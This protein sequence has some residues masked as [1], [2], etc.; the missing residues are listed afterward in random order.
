MKREPLAIV[1]MACRFPGNADSADALWD[2][3]CKGTDAIRE[4][5]VDRWDVRKFFDPDPD[6]LGKGYTR[7]G[8][9]LNES[10]WEFDPAFFGISPR[11][12]AVMDPQQRL[13]LEVTWE[14]FEDAGMVLSDE[15][16]KRVGVFVGAFCFD[17][18]VQQ[19]SQPSRT[20]ISSHTATSAS[21][22]MLSNRISYVFDLQ[23][24]SLTVDT[25]CSS[26]LVTTHLGCQA[27]WDGDCDV[28]VVGGVNVML[29]PESTILECKGG[30]LSK[31]ARCRTFDA[32][33]NGYVRAEGAGVV[34]I[35]PLSAALAAKDRIVAVIRGTGVNQDGRTSSI[36][37]PNGQAQEALIRQVCAATGIDPV[38]IGYVEAHGTGTPV[39]DPIE[40]N[41]LGNAIGQGREQACAPWVG[42]IKT[43][44]GHLEAAAGVA[45]L[46]KA[47]L[48]LQHQQVPPHLHLTRLNPKIDLHT[49]GLRVPQRM[50]VLEPTL[51]R[52]AAINSFGYGGTNAHALIERAP[53]PA[54]VEP[55]VEDRGPWLVPLSARTAGALA[56]YAQAVAQQLRAQPSLSLAAFGHALA[57]KRAHHDHRA[58]IVAHDRAGLL[59]SLAR[60][61]GGET[62]PALRI[63]R[64]SEGRRLVW[65]YTGMGAQ[66]W[67]MGRS[68]FQSNEVFRAAIAACDDAWRHVGGESLSSVFDPAAALAAP[69]G[70]P[71]CEPRDAQPANLA[72]QVGVTQV[73]R[74][75]GLEADAIVGHSVGE[76]GAAWA[77]GAL[78]LQEAFR[79]TYHRSQ[80]QQELLG[81][82]TMLALPMPAAA[83]REQI[84]AL[85]PDVE[86]AAFNDA[87]SVTLSGREEDLLR[88]ADWARTQG[89][90]AQLLRV[91]VAY[92]TRQVDPIRE[93]FHAALAGL[94][95]QP[96]PITLYS[97]VTGAKVAPGEQDV[98]YWWRNAREPVLLSDAMQQLHSDGFDA[99]IEVG[100]HAVLGASILRSVPNAASWPSQRR[101]ASDEQATLLAAA[102][103]AYCAGASIDWRRLYPR[104]D[105][106]LR[107]PRYPFQRETLWR[108]TAASRADRLV[109]EL[110]PLLH[111]RLAQPMPAWR[112]TL[113]E[114]FLPWL[115]DHRI[116]GALVFPG[117]GYAVAAL[118]AAD[119]T[120]RGNAVENLEFSRP[121][122]PSSQTTLQID[123]DPRDGHVSLSSQPPGEDPAWHRH[124][125]ARLPEGRTAAPA[126]CDI[127]QLRARCFTAVDVEQFYRQLNEQGLQ[128][129]P[130]FRCIRALAVGVD[131]AIVTLRSEDVE[132]SRYLVHPALLDAAFQSMLGLPGEGQA[133]G[134]YVPVLV[135]ALRL[136]GPVGQNVIAHVKVSRRTP[137]SIQG[138]IRLLDDT[139]R[140]L[141]AVEGVRCQ[142][143]GAPGTGDDAAK[144]LYAWQWETSPPAEVTEAKGA[145][146]LVLSDH[147]GV[148]R[149][150][151]DAA[152]GLTGLELVCLP[153]DFASSSA[154]SL[155]AYS[156]VI[157]LRAVDLDL[158]GD[159]PSGEAACARL[160]SLVQKLAH[161]G[162]TPPK[163]VVVTHRALPVGRVEVIP[164]SGAVCGLARVAMS[165]LP[166]LA[167]R[168][169]DIDTRGAAEAHYLLAE[170][171]S[172]GDENEV[173]LRGGDRLVPRLDRWQAAPEPLAQRS[174]DEPVRLVLG[175]PGV[176]D[177]LHWVA[178]RRRPPGRGEVEIRVHNTSLNFKDL[179]KA[180]NMLS[181][182]Y[183]ETTFI[184]EHLGMECSGTVV[185][186]GEGV[187]DYAPGDQV[188]AIDTNG[189]FRSYH[190]V[191]TG[192][193][194]HKP[195]VLS[196]DAAPSLIAYVTPYYALNYLAN[197]QPGET[198]LIHS[199]SGGVGLAAIEVARWLGAEVVATAGSD[200]K[201]AFLR[202]RGVAHVFDS[203]TL[204]FAEDVMKLTG[205][206]GVDVVL[207]S[208]SA[209]AARKS[210]SVLA[211]HGRFLEI[212]KKD[213]A[214]GGLLGLADFDRNLMYAAVDTDRMGA[215]R[216]VLFRRLIAEVLELI[217]AR[218]I[219]ALPTQVYPAANV[220][221]AFRAMARAQHI[222]KIVLDTSRGTVQVEQGRGV[223]VRSD[224]SWL[225]TGGL[226]GFGLQV[227][228]WLVKQGVRELVLVGRTGASRPEARQAIGEMEATGVKVRVE[229]LD[230]ADGSAVDRLM[231]SV[232]AT[233]APL[234]GIVHGAMVLDD[235]P[236]DG[237]TAER[238][239][240][241]MRPK[242]LGAWNLHRASL[243]LPI[244]AFV[245]FSSVASFIG[246]ASQGAYVA[247]NGFL[248]A[249]AWHRHAT[250][251]P[252]L[253]VNWG[254]IADTGVV[255]RSEGTAAYLD[256]MGIA[257][258]AATSCT[259]ALGQLLGTD[260]TQVG[261][262]EMNWSRWAA[263]AGVVVRSPRFGRLITATGKSQ[264]EDSPVVTAL[265]ALPQEERL[266]QLQEHLREQLARVMHQ[267]AS[268][269]DVSLSL[270][271]MGVDSLMAVE[272][273]NRLRSELGVELS[274]MT[275]MMHGATVAKLAETLQQMLFPEGEQAA[276]AAA[277]TTADQ[278]DGMSE[279]ELD[280]LLAL[281]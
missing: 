21:M 226:G 27:I 132:A 276:Q 31:D 232:A 44:M 153:A 77:A 101:G 242:A 63:G 255:A 22:V 3:L 138:E 210:L 79:L 196:F 14:A 121:L 251:R 207:N 74:S 145:R 184:G 129:G 257:G 197:T 122:E 75:L 1:G 60:L 115:P 15:L 264:S 252:A 260:A 235:G 163:L 223:T 39:G 229:A 187:T 106:A 174:V 261:V 8:G 68:L 167:L 103:E 142:R 147:A 40:A 270:D 43:N 111:E 234:Q 185:A 35:R 85:A 280:A 42:S 253:T 86:I 182:A 48:C 56:A 110:H 246:N 166:A 17:N 172:T 37:V 219:G 215:E 273:I 244:E 28:A 10:I 98:A 248:D 189:C 247:A 30:F 104:G 239:A 51:G 150:L 168:L 66:W 41:A 143:V 125:V 190:T 272:L 243:A 231:A 176:L 222:G 155:A 203:R 99:F 95:T 274:A 126:A 171:L 141:L 268:K 71:M 224:R 269:V 38:Q 58:L 107:A 6:A 109:E 241:V 13:M 195:E 116:T 118:A 206:R 271:N 212:G 133:S 135:R 81:L 157:D 20:A 72:L 205:G 279:A 281:G 123:F 266:P 158:Q 139:G 32:S 65:V 192:Y 119:V 170:A 100:P 97:T 4:V 149:R 114:R 191:G 67:G 19:L 267:D 154:E 55:A 24:P 152:L 128:Y 130:A 173:A 82:G 46:M 216:P 199:A 80:L 225:V 238:L 25:A 263:S 233:M 220:G 87:L 178:D 204:E 177:S 237:M 26:S 162:P 169:V 198:V 96:H 275:V 61:V 47:A 221:D 160:M 69:H 208:L 36:T 117:A 92:H 164:A 181:A 34:V 277:L 151:E 127:A 258:M 137:G 5:P 254:A 236:I 91:G 159:D 213:I 120:G 134:T 89:V 218:Q 83:A 188:I 202:E 165:E 146:W 70:E 7:Q 23:G 12:A 105:T 161:A 156:G 240:A 217:S 33:A 52:F 50:E 148:A 16:R 94:E 112:T 73:L 90:S 59:L 18:A 108:E 76:I 259:Q 175:T 131:E 62:E 214:E 256:N 227:A 209:E 211:S 93:R 179:M 180:L 49:L 194:F 11:E 57:V 64:G 53:E 249:L 88:I 144:R 200:T 183:I 201:R 278:V 124:A 140:V 230:V 193:L 136:H 245:T 29:R 250:G 265:R 78:S 45:G 2:M 113:N 102:S 84:L 186:V 262:V 9:F 228:R 54:Q